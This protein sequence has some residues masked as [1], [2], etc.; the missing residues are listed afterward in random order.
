MLS[1]LLRLR[2]LDAK[3]GTHFHLGTLEKR[4]LADEGL[5]DILVRVLGG[6]Q[7]EDYLTSSLNIM[8]MDLLVSLDVVVIGGSKCYARYCSL[9]RF[10]DLPMSF[11]SQKLQRHFNHLVIAANMEPHAGARTL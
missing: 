4:D 8:A 11:A 6:D 5:A 10:D 7:D 3:W 1:L 2:L 9:S